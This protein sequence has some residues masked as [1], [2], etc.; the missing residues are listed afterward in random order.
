MTQLV[1]QLFNSIIIKQSH[2]GFRRDWSPDIASE[3]AS[4]GL[5][6]CQR[7][8]RRLTLVLEEE[9]P[10]LLESERIT[11]LRTIRSLPP[12]FT[13][14]EQ[15]KLKADNFIHELG[16]VCNISPCYED[17][18]SKG[19]E[20]YRQIALESCSRPGNTPEQIDFLRSVVSGIEAVYGLCERYREKAQRVGNHIVSSLLSSLPQ[21]GATTFH[22]ALQL[23]RILHF[24][25][26]CE[27]EYHNT[28][29]RF[30][31]Y[32]YPYL[33][34]DLE[35]G[36]I[37]KDDAYDLLLEFFLTFNR[38][39]DLYTGVQQGDNGQSMVLGGVDTNGKP[40]FNLLSRM[41]LAA[42]RELKLIDPKINLRV[43]K[44]TPHEI[45]VMGT[46]LTKIGLGFP[47]YSNDDVVIPGLVDL[48]YSLE[49]ARNYT[50]AACWE[51]IV[52]KYGMDIPNIAALSFPSAVDNCLQRD[53]CSINSFDD[54]MNM[55]KSEIIFQCDN[56]I[57]ST[58][59]LWMIPS[60]FMSIMMDGCLDNGRDISLGGR[61]NNYG[62]HGTGLSTAADSLAAIKKYVF[63]D[64]I[65]SLPQLAAAVGCN[66][67]G[68]DELLA[69]LRYESP[70]MGNDDCADDIAV[71]LLN[72]FADALEGKRN[73]RGG[74]YRAGTGSAMYYLWHAN[75]IGAS[76]DGRRKFEAF[77]ANY[78]PSLFARTSGPLSV[79]K[80]FV[81]PNLQRCINGGPLTMEFSETLFRTPASMEKMA[82]LVKVFIDSGG[83]Q[84]QLNAINVERLLDAQK[85]PERYR[86]LIV[87]IWG[88]SAY[89]VDL[90][91]EF[92][93]HVISRQVYV[94]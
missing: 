52:P 8:S 33:K 87:R 29:G 93:D 72:T 57:D 43:N 68:Y 76:P 54:C 51:F 53:L 6:A 10:V 49:D 48:G 83:H 1:K 67:E 5:T 30:D 74:C 37:S 50:M 69:K 7:V 15:K 35:T 22:E 44:E 40:C 91:K 58:K 13:P 60:P 56:L 20:H 2:Y 61:Y 84:F 18:I 38:D 12:I 24:T 59:G 90:D 21:R 89:F 86:N 23:F 81:K 88:W 79:I 75:D 55:V 19:L 3:F 14:E 28:V 71:Q 73:D 77:S 65:L 47:Q 26:W 42:S 62:F 64:K 9:E 45:Y 25:L 46:E 27:G 34:S 78:A 92:Q 16:S 94:L 39:S 82:S 4:A 63:E 36:K 70:K 85:N 17:V 11:L 32:M 31:Q 66:F 41:C 80:S